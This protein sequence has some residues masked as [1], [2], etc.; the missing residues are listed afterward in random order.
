MQSSELPAMVAAGGAP[1]QAVIILLHVLAQISA[2]GRGTIAVPV[3]ACEG[4]IS[5]LLTCG[6]NGSLSGRWCLTQ[7]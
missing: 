7:M 6:S 4:A 2:P 3:F 5:A 1:Q